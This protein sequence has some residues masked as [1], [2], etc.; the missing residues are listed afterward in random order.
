MGR[1]FCRRHA[2]DGAP[3][4]MRLW[5]WVSL[6]I[7]VPTLAATPCH[8]QGSAIPPIALRVVA[9]GLEH[10]VHIAAA[11]GENDRLYVVEQAGS[12]RIIQD[13]KVRNPRFLDIRDRVDSGGEKGLLSI[14]FHPQYAKNGWFYVDYTTRE[15]GQLYTIVS[16]FQRGPSGGGDE[17]SEE[18]LLKIEQPYSNHNG[19]QLAFGPDGFL[20]IGMGDGGS[21]NDPHGNGQNRGNL[22]GDLLRI[23]VD[24]PSPTR[25]Y[26]IPADNPFVNQ[27][28]VR[29]E[30]YAYGLRNPWRFSF[31][32]R[33]ALLYLA[34]VGQDAQEEIDIV[35]KGKNYGWNIMEGD[36][37]T[38]GVKSRCNK[39]GLELPIATYDHRAGFSITGGFV[40]RGSRFPTLCGVYLY[41]DY[42]TKRVWG[43][44]FDGKR[45]TTS[46]ELLRTD[47]A[48]SSFGQDNALELY[49]ADHEGGRV[50]QVAVP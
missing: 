22:L 17:G 41:A 3:S 8:E 43:L 18:V 33:T 16:R 30:I 12:V 10:P 5:L 25:P 32:A 40:Y 24:A 36:L 47:A 39:Q 15:K 49:V 23:D 31:D 7:A 42:V 14:A 28:G 20:Y 44:R 26:A 1:W 37:C 2:H 6:G 45:V 48:I 9:E 46:R 19:G 38:P 50:L 13:G 34:D 4:R 29:P 11:P 21:A 27:R 35:R